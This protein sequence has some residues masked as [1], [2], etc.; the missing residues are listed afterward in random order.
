MLEYGSNAIKKA[1]EGK[2]LKGKKQGIIFRD[3]IGGFGLT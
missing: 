3:D 2:E 1:G